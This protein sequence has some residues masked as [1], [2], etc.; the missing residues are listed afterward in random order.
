[1]HS[2]KSYLVICNHISWWDGFWVLRL[3]KLIFKKQFHVAML[4]SELRK[5]RFLSYVGAF[6]VP[7]SL[8][9][10]RK[11]FQ[12]GKS[13]LDNKENMLL[14]FP[15]GEFASL[16]DRDIHFKNGVWQLLNQSQENVEVVFVG[17]F[18]DYYSHQK[19]T[20]FSYVELYKRPFSGLIDLQHAYQ[21]FYDTCM[22]HQI[23]N[24]ET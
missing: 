13:I 21:V 17:N 16:Y 15:Q 8:S 10:L 22:T 3:N 6:S 4:E 23:N 18:I 11:F 19:P 9:E 24:K 1:M 5:N 7:S 14:F 2:H 20:L 12:V